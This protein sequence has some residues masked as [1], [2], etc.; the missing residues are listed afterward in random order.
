MQ[1]F[2]LPRP[3]LGLDC[4]AAGPVDRLHSRWASRGL[5]IGY[6][7]PVQLWLNHEEVPI[8]SGEISWSVASPCCLSAFGFE[9]EVEILPRWRIVELVHKQHTVI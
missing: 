8:F 1:R 6:A 5:R 3:A 7:S 2:K 4:L 9:T